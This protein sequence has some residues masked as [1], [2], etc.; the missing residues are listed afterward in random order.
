MAKKK[1]NPKVISKITIVE[2]KGQHIKLLQKGKKVVAR[3]KGG[4]AFNNLNTDNDF[5]KWWEETIDALG[6]KTDINVIKSEVV[7]N[8]SM[9]AILSKYK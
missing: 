7:P 4:I 8:K 2:I 9:D 5:D 6:D 1:T 3:V